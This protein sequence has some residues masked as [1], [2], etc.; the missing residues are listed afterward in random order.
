MAISKTLLET[1]DKLETAG[2]SE[3]ASIIRE[4]AENIADQTTAEIAAIMNDPI[5]GNVRARLAQA[6]RQGRVTMDDMVTSGIDPDTLG[7]VDRSKGPTHAR[8]MKP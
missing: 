1:A 2:I 8:I 6:Y 5:R 3:G 7:Y 4:A